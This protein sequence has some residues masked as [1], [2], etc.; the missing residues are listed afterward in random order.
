VQSLVLGAVHIVVSKSCNLI[1]VFA[2]DSLAA[3]LVGR[4][5]WVRVQQWLFGTILGAFALRLL[6]E[7]RQIAMTG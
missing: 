4:P 5:A 7:R 3:F 6:M 1:W 2:A